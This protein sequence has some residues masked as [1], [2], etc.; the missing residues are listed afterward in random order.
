MPLPVLANVAEVVEPENLASPKVAED[1]MEFGDLANQNV[2][3]RQNKFNA[4]STPNLAAGERRNLRG[5][6]NFNIILL[7]LNL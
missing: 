6:N 7:R 1:V 2:I 4:R 5:V 3:S